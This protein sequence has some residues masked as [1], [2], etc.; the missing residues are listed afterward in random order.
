MTWNKIIKSFIL[1]I[2]LGITL[3]SIVGYYILKLTY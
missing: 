3:A 1:S 2:I